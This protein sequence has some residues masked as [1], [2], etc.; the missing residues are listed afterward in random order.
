[1]SDISS[2]VT[3]ANQLSQMSEQALNLNQNW[4]LSGKG[5]KT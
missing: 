3:G 5:M 2:H 4:Q 1:M